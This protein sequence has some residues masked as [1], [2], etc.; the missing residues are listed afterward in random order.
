MRKA[1]VE[2][3][4]L[5]ACLLVIGVHV[6]LSTVVN[7]TYDASRLLSACL[8]ADG[9]DIFWL[10]SGFFMFNTKSYWKLLKRTFKNI[11]IPMIIFLIFCF[12]LSGYLVDRTSLAVSIC[13]LY[14]S[15]A[16]DE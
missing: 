1:S 4:R 2:L 6:S 3:A 10:I 16:A 7:D 9:V 15:D 11:V 8:V 13:L 5:I 14:T 12:F